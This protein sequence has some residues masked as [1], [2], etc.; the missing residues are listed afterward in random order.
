[1]SRQRDAF[2]PFY[3]L[4]ILAGVAFALTAC[5]YGAMT[6]VSLRGAEHGERVATGFVS[7]MN[8]YGGRLM[9]IE[10]GVLAVVSIAAMT[11]DEWWRARADRSRSTDRHDT[12]S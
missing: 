4:I 2:N 8:A 9:A 10:V 11:T 12:T 1:V 5:A 6:V 3:P 7:F